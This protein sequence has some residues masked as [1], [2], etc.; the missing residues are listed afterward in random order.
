MPDMTVVAQDLISRSM[1]YT[2]KHTLTSGS[3]SLCL[4]E[5]PRFQSP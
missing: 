3:D 2:P 5:I 4:G 1:E